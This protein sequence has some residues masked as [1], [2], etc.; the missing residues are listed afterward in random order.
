MAAAAGGIIGGLLGSESQAGQKETVKVGQT[1]QSGPISN[2]GRV[3][4]AG[5]QQAIIQNAQVQPAASNAPQV[6][7]SNNG[8]GSLSWEQLAQM[9]KS[10]N[11]KEEEEPKPEEKTKVP[12]ML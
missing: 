7:S 10:L 6:T 12:V 9:A 11:S 8:N 1:S 3:S 4:N 5:N 2:A